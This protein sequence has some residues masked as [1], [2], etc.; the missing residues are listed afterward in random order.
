MY[1]TSS[2]Y[3]NNS[4][5]QFQHMH[6]NRIVKHE[7]ISMHIISKQQHVITQIQVSE[8]TGNKQ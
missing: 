7:K 4:K 3:T 5:Y 6:C 8:L 1:D 2:T